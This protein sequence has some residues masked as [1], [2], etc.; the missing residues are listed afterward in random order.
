MALHSQLAGLVLGIACLMS[1]AP[2]PEAAAISEPQRHLTVFKEE[3]R[4]GGWPANNGMWSW[5]D[6]IL[7]GFVD[8]HFK[9][10][11][12][13][14]AIDGS[15]P[16]VLRFAR[17]RDGGESWT[18][19]VPH[20][21]TPEGRE[22]EP[23]ESPGGFDFSHPDAAVAFRMVSSREGYSRYY[24]SNDRGRQWQG[25]Y[26]IPTYGRTG[27]AARTDYLV[28]GPRELMAFMTAHKEDGR[29]GRVFNV[30]TNDGGRTWEF[31][32]W[33]GPEPAGFSIMPSSVRLAPSRILTTVR[34]KEGDEHWI[35]SWIS[36]DDGT[37][38]A[39]LNRVASTGGSVG[40]PPATLR[41]RDGRL[42]IAYG[43]RSA[44]FGIR[45]RIS[46]DNGQSW[47]DEIV[48]RADGGNWD[49][50]YPTTVQR[51]DGKLVTVYY[52]NDHPDQERYI[53]ATIW[54][55]DALTVTADGSS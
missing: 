18:L 45:A 50:G 11:E 39:F 33:I 53:A 43:Y 48:L 44:P 25:P 16:S 5:G 28:N 9:Q 21:L 34:R 32:S 51:E 49:L 26:R 37:S 4:F 22:P 47:G 17:S 24:Y 54:D 13:G 29:E 20:F 8:G 42:A 14:H 23:V 10:V 1:C 3:G 31:V 40:N 38:W 12:R 36:H 19:E 2:R 52:F 30:R 35:E 15:K 41:L 46:T 27:I 7:V 6:E 55:P